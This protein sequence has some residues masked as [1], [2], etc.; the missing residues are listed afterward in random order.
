REIFSK[1]ASKVPNTKFIIV[2]DGPL[3]NE[4]EKVKGIDM[5][6]TGFISQQEVAKYMNAMD[7]MILPS[8]NEGWPCVALEAQACGTCVIGSNNGGIPE[9]VGFSEYVIE[10][11]VDFEK[12]IAERVVEVLKSGYDKE[13]L[14]DRA[15]NYTWENT[16]SREIE[17]FEELAKR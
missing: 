5:T 14:I 3:R 7:V 10:D 8:R 16:V 6:I 13:K 2:G 15:K 17:L 9:A 12:R 11:G 4:V 1:I